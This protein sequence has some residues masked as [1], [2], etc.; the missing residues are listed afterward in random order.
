MSQYVSDPPEENKLPTLEPVAPLAQKKRANLS[1]MGITALFVLIGLSLLLFSGQIIVGLTQTS[2]ARAAQKAFPRPTPGTFM[3]QNAASPTPAQ[4]AAP[5]PTPTPVSPFF[6]P[7]NADAPALQLPGGHSVVYQSTTHLY[8]VSTTDNSILPIYTPGYTYSQAVRPILT[9]DGRLIY[10]GDQGIWITDVFDPQPTQIAHLDANMVVASL[11]LSQDGKV[12][13]W[14]TE[15]T[16]GMGQMS[17]YAGPL[18]SP[19][20]I[21]Q[22]TLDCPCFRIFSFSNGTG[23]AADQTLLLTDDRGGSNEAVQYGLW[24]L[25]IST[26]SATPQLLMDESSQQGPL[27]FVPYSN[28]LLYAPYEGAVPVPTDGSVPSDVAALSY[29]NSLSITTLDS[30]SL[31]Q[32]NSQVVL[33]RQKNPANSGQDHWVTTPTFSPDG[34]TLAYVEFSS[35]TQDPYDRHSALYTVQINSSGS[36]IQAGHP[37]LVATSTA[38]LFELGPWLNSHVITMYGDGSLYALDVQSGAMT[39]LAQPGGYLRLLAVVGTGRT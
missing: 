8:L 24:S 11:A 36:Q 4:G 35:D 12:I 1:K 3:A 21:R 20:L 7:S 10:S 22:S 30:S 25:D 33:P 27:A 39:T 17:I 29:A 13:A 14:S 26:P 19:Q 6:S 18:T 9:P 38:R 28:T 23:S 16:D 2:P 32:G 34:H 15:P 37:Q 31:Q 5:T